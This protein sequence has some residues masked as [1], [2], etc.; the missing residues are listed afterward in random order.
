MTARYIHNKVAAVQYLLF[1]DAVLLFC[2]SVLTKWRRN[3]AQQCAWAVYFCDTVFLTTRAATTNGGIMST[4]D[5][6]FLI[7]ILAFSVIALHKGFVKELFGKVCFT[8]AIA[9]SV[10]FSPLVVVHLMKVINNK[11]LCIAL[12]Y[13]T[14]F[15]VVFLVLRITQVAVEAMFSG[16]VLGSLN[17]AL[18]FILG[19]AEGLIIVLLIMVI[20]S[21]QSVVNVS[22]ITRGSSFFRTFAPLI[23][24]TIDHANAVQRV[25]N[26]PLT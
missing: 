16:D 17:R 13:F 25:D 14:V 12:S 23:D 3:I 10:F 22:K 21:V 24:Y 19:A 8:G 20:M 15:V 26:I 11:P 6:L 4:I 2:N 1:Y 18:G 7:I 9:A 5:I